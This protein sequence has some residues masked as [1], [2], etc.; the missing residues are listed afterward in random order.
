MHKSLRPSCFRTRERAVNRA[1]VSTSLWTNLESIV[2]ETIKEQKEPATV[3]DA[4]MNQL[5]S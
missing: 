4:A 1:S 2:L 5:V 3:A